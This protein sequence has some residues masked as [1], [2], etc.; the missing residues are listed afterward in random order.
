MTGSV[1]RFLAGK[2]QTRRARL[3]FA[4]DATASRQPTWDMAVRLQAE[5]FREILGIGNL[6]VQL[7]FYRG[8]RDHGGECKASQWMPPTGLTAAMQRIVCQAGETQIGKVL[9]HTTRETQDLAVGALVFVGDACEEN[10]DSL[11][12]KAAGMGVPAFMFQEYNAGLS[13]AEQAVV[14][15]T[16]KAVALASHGAYCRFD[17][18]AARQ[19]GE[20]L[21]AVVAFVV[22]GVQ[23]LEK[24]KTEGATKLLSQLK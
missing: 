23:A 24:Q 16:F 8:L 21:R 15:K 12:T 11:T 3:I 17:E 19:L 7:V 14:E 1:D 20:L 4:L 5:M 9:S 10:A 18:G 13:P 22:G 6:D 2:A